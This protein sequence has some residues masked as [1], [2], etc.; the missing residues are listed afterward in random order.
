[1]PSL[2]AKLA[3]AGAMAADAMRLAI[4]LAAVEG[5]VWEMIAQDPTAIERPEAIVALSSVFSAAAG[6]SPAAAAR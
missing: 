3:A 6:F 4:A 5:A 1:M 2:Q